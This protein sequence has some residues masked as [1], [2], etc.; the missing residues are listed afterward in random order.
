MADLPALLTLN[1]AS[2]P[3]VNSIELDD[4]VHFREMT[5]HFLKWVEDDGTAGFVIALTPGCDY[6]SLNYQ[7]FSDQYDQFLYIDRIIVTPDFRR[8]GIA[9]KMYA[10]LAEI[11]VRED[12]KRLTCEVNSEPPNPGSMQMHESVGFEMTGT[13]RTEGGKKEVALLVKAVG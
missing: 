12:L 8:R 10:A 3:H 5:P 7:W 1:E 4:M 6:D 11:A 9:S 13:Q 2:I